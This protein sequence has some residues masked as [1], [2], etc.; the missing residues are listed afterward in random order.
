MILSSENIGQTARARFAEIARFASMMSCRCHVD[1]ASITSHHH[2][3]NP[4]S[5]WTM[6]ENFYNSTWSDNFPI[7]YNVAHTAFLDASILF[8]I[9]WSVLPICFALSGSLIFADSGSIATWFCC[10]LSLLFLFVGCIVMTKYSQDAGIARQHDYLGPM[11][12]KG[13]HVYSR[14][15]IMGCNGG[16]TCGGGQ[17]FDDCCFYHEYAIKVEL[18]WGYDWSCENDQK[19]LSFDTYEPCTNTACKSR[20]PSFECN[21]Q[22][23]QEAELE[24]RDCAEMLYRTDVTYPVDYNPHD[25]PGNDWPTWLAFG[26]CS[27]CTTRFIVPSNR[28]IR[29][30]KITGYV[31]LFIGSLIW[32]V[33]L[34]RCGFN[35]W[36][37]RRRTRL[38]IQTNDAA[39]NPHPSATHENDYGSTSCLVVQDRGARA[40][41]NYLSENSYQDAV[42]DPD[43]DY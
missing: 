8:G 19:C 13:T 33:M 35:W 22:E 43:F 32:I 9:L 21:T 37:R 3:I 12:V 4:A 15:T 2:H 34:I 39:G 11:R 42:Y 28:K 36:K 16:Y 20:W 26:D 14:Q 27:T 31:L 29:Q 5:C 1:D 7:D 10:W 30:I 38:G 23:L 40:H 17:G 6:S 41:D 18:E 24:T 25:A